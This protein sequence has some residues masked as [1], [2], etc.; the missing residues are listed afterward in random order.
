MEAALENENNFFD[1]ADIYTY[2]KSE[3]SFP[4]I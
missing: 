2:G 1:H 4:A 3:E